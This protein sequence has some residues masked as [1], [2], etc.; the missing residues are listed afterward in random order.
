MLIRKKVMQDVGNH[1]RRVAEREETLEA[2]I[3]VIDKAMLD[4]FLAL[5]EYLMA[6][7]GD[8]RDHLL[9]AIEDLQQQR[10][11]LQTI[12]DETQLARLA[13]AMS[14]QLHR[15]P[16]GLPGRG[17]ARD[18][19]RH[20]ESVE[21]YKLDEITM[22]RCAEAIQPV[23]R[24]L[25][26]LDSWCQN[27]NNLQG[28]K[29]AH[30]NAKAYAAE[31]R[32][33]RAADVRQSADKV[34][35]GDITGIT[36]NAFDVLILQPQVAL[37]VERFGS[38]AKRGERTRARTHLRF[39]RLGGYLIF[40]VPYFK[41]Y[42]DLRN[43]LAKSLEDVQIRKGLD[44]EQTGNVI[45][46]GRKK[47]G[48]QLDRDTKLSLEDALEQGSIPNIIVTPFETV[49][50]PEQ[51]MSIELFKGS[52][53]DEAEL[54]RLFERSPAMKSFWNDQKA[55]ELHEQ[56]GKPPLPFNEGRIGLVLAS[57]FLDGIIDEQNGHSHIVKG[58]VI[59]RQEEDSEVRGNEVHVTQTESNRV[60]I[61]MLLPDGQ[62]KTL[63]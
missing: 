53:L 31:T 54:Q 17:G 60:E 42:Q 11:S 56:V 46:L 12:E 25:N 32:E 49:E 35:V 28:F 19:D 13:E 2:R 16:D 47:K 37:E 34:A 55:K 18:F 10:L 24:E 45:I 62:H 14:A 38:F 29:R 52:V 26:V 22:Q 51:P 61:N 63:A 59:R 43:D 5:R 8:R 21:S 9:T 40:V 39:L 33:D 15:I 23:D 3:N 48:S 36:N 57:G 6:D 7:R 41:L 30:P 4:V 58:R 44:Y 27:H 20:Y 50:L 1:I